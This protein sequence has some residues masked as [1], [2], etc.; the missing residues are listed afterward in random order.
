MSTA[1]EYRCLACTS[2]QYLGDRSNHNGDAA[3]EVLAARE[4]LVRLGG[5]DKSAGQAL[6]S[7]FGLGVYGILGL[8]RWFHEHAGHDVRLF[9]EYGEE[10]SA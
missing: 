7:L 6:E 10:V 9:T 5:L 1:Y 8:A 3:R 2:T 4:A